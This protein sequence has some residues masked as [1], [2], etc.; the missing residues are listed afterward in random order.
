MTLM[1]SDREMTIL[2]E[3]ATKRGLSKTALLRQALSLY[4]SVTQRL[5][6]GEKLYVEHPGTKEKAELVV[7]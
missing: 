7:L 3:L 1:L 4:Q 6:S 2:E 5:S